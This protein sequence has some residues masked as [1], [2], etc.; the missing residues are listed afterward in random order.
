MIADI[1]LEVVLP[2]FLLIA[3]GSWMQKVFKLDLYTLAK[4]NFYCITPAAVFM[5]MY[6]SNM[7]GELL[8]TVTLFYAIYVLI[9]YIIGSVVSRSFRMNKGMKAAFNNSIMLD[10]AGNYGLPINALVFRGDPLASSIQA[11]VMSLQALLTFTY[12]VLSIQGAKLKGNY[13]AVII[14]FLKM[15]VPYALLLGI[16]FQAWKLPLPTFLSMPL[17]YA[18]QS[19]VSVALLT[20]GAQ[21]V[22]Y[23]I[24]L[25]RLDVYISTFLRLLIGP[26][27]GRR[28][29]VLLLGLEGIAAQALII[30]SGMPTGVNSSILAEEYDNEPDF[31]AQTVL[32]STLLNII[33]ITALISY[34]KTF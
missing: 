6:H 23:P 15:P 18:Q 7:S 34:A 9:L 5:S 10:N 11:L 21:I 13:R 32:I 30:A 33:T 31:A 16:L 4:I 24:R 17:T 29:N 28:K 19:M 2:V 25:Y 8:G 27:I 1:M 12:G 20:L 3:V 26:A 14:G 22:K